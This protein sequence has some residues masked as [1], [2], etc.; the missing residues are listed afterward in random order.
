MSLPNVDSAL[1]GLGDPLSVAVIAKSAQDFEARET[2]TR[3]QTVYGVQVPTEPRKLLL[4]PEGERQ[5]RYLTFYSSDTSLR[6]DYYV[7]TDDKAQYRVV[8]VEPWGS[9]NVYLLQECPT[10]GSAGEAAED[11]A[12]EASS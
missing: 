5:W 10:A 4:L 12:A 7:E 2:I 3:F 6:N 1:Q 11:F 9:Y 8:S